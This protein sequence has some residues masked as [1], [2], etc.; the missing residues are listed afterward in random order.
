MSQE[1]DR[2]DRDRA[3]SLADRLERLQDDISMERVLLNIRVDAL[4]NTAQAI[5][6]EDTQIE[7]FRS[8]LGV[9]IA[10]LTTLSERLKDIV[11]SSFEEG[12]S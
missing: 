11:E 10:E 12:F 8:G 4:R 9:A 7:Y 5:S 6:F 3:E 2:L 1:T